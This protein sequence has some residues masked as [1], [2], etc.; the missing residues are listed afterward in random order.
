[1]RPGRGARLD[2]VL[3]DRDL[4]SIWV[5]DPV[6]VAWLLGADT[7]VDSSSQT[8]VAAVGYDGEAVTAVVPSNDADRLRTEELPDTVTV[9]PFDWTAGV[10]EGVLPDLTVGARG[11]DVPLPGFEPVEAT[12]FTHPLVEAD[13]ATYREVGAATAAA[14]EGAARSADATSTERE[15]AADLRARLARRDVTATVVLVG[16]AA[17]AQ[18][19]RHPTPQDTTL[20][21]YAVV[22]VTGRRNGL[23]ASCTRTVTFDAPGWLRERHATAC[24]IEAEAVAATERV[25]AAGGSAAEVFAAIRDAYA[26]VGWPDEWRAHHQGGATGYAGRA[27]VAT[28]DADMGV[29]V[30][31][32]YAYNPTVAGAKSEDT[33]LLTA[34]EREVLTATG[35]WPTIAVDAGDVVLERPAVLPI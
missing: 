18:R 16:G 31:M 26:S 22:S 1:M 15:V 34:D 9:E 29:E 5:L 28:P 10:V 25:A 21:G 23:H 27:W 24:R 11:A 35:D 33:H 8:G 14:V 4:D 30:P 2:A 20:G 3:A 6:N 17:R 19:Y 12:A 7:V 13:L 32:G